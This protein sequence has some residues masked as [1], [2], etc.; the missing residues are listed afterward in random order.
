M[1]EG[2]AGGVYFCSALPRAEP[3][4]IAGIPSCHRCSALGHHGG[5]RQP[6]HPDHAF[7]RDDTAAHLQP[8]RQRPGPRHRRHT[9]PPSARHPPAPVDAGPLPA[10][11]AALPASQQ[12]GGQPPEPALV[13]QQPAPQHVL[14]ERCGPGG[15]PRPRGGGQ[16]PPGLPHAAAAAASPALGRPA[17]QRTRHQR[18]GSR[19]AAPQHGRGPGQHQRGADAAD[20]WRGEVRVHGPLAPQR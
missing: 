5:S 11:A 17:Q 3:V 20:N 1:Q 10:P 14:H 8:G 6:A 4:A 12:H 7:L 9:L 15:P 18:A 16:R 19:P 13:H 2:K